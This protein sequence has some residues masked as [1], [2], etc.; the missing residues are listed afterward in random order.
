MWH[1]MNELTLRCVMSIKSWMWVSSGYNT[2]RVS[3]LQF[4]FFSRSFGRKL[5]YNFTSKKVGAYVVDKVT[6]H[7]IVLSWL[8]RRLCLIWPRHGH[9]TCRDYRR[10]P[11][12]ILPQE[13]PLNL[14][15]SSHR[16]HGFCIFF[17]KKVSFSYKKKKIY[18]SFCS[19]VCHLTL[20]TNKPVSFGKFINKS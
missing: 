1:V 19:F 11:H 13:L 9:A 6:F 17:F 10:I 4:L 8:E 20:F 15:S 16:R 14:T 7:C 2:K 3:L 12:H 18:N 5:W